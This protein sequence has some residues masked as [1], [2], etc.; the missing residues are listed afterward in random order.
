MKI[1]SIDPGYDRIGFAVLEKNKGDKKETLIFSECFTTNKKEILNKRIFAVGQELEFLIKKF[2]PEIMAIEK[3]FFTSN[4]KTVMGVSEA[5]GVLIYVA[6][7]NNLDVFEYTPLEIKQAVAGYGRA[8]KTQVHDMTKKLV[9]LDNKKYIDD[10][11]DAIAIGLTA[12]AYSKNLS[13]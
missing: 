3:L 7:V 4:Q 13:R 10:E 2:K 12:F 6:Q 5:R 9:T 1:I 11:I 8:D